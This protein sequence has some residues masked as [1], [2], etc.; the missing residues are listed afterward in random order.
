MGVS[1]GYDYRDDPLGIT[2]YF[3]RELTKKGM[4]KIGLPILKQFKI[5][6]LT[7]IILLLNQYNNN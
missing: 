1:G 6:W 4:G 5:I 3:N 7:L 2:D